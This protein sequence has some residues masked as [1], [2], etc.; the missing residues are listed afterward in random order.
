MR[1]IVFDTIVLGSLLFNTDTVVMADWKLKTTP[2]VRLK[3]MTE[4][5]VISF[6]S[7][8]VNREH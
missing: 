8:S 2:V 7:L 1:H 3:T 5:F 6:V 4:R